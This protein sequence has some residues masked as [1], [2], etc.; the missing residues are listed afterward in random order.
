MRNILVTGEERKNYPKKPVKLFLK[1]IAREGG[2]YIWVIYMLSSKRVNATF[3]E[4]MPK[5]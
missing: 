1:F 2:A 4:H 5:R 3:V